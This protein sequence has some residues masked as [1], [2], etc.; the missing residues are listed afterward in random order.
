MKTDFS[1]N[2]CCVKGEQLGLSQVSSS[3]YHFRKVEEGDA[4]RIAAIFNYFV[5]NSY[6]AYETVK[7]ESDFLFKLR[8]PSPDHPFYVIEK[9][10]EIVGF[11]L[12][13][14]HRKGEAFKHVAEISYFVLPE[15]TK[16]GLGT[17]LLET[18]ERE[19]ERK[20]IKTLLANIS[21]LNSQS[22]AFH[23]KNGFETCG[24]FRRLG[25]KF[26]REFDVV[27]TQKFL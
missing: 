20:G 15:H 4:D 6:A 7:V 18:L 5:E 17:R 11:G 16:K 10:T 12:V 2:L 8:S 21:S 14:K 13:R 3:D 22:L 1:L 19:V 24:R 9:D 23:E 25:S 27:W 26:G